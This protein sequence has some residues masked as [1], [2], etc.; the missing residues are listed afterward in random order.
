MQLACARSNYGNVER[1][2]LFRERGGEARE[3]QIAKENE[4]NGRVI[5][6][7]L[8]RARR[9][10][11][12]RNKRFASRLPNRRKQKCRSTTINSRSCAYTCVGRLR[13]VLHLPHARPTPLRRCQNFTAGYLP[14]TQSNTSLPGN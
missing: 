6:N 1:F 3:I 9:R 4:R 2:C 8:I 14:H 7:N 10:C 5:V 11:R 12:S 13:S